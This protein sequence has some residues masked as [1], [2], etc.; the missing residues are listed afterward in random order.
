[1]RP[2]KPKRVEVNPAQ[3]G[4]AGFGDALAG[5]KLGPLP[6]GP[7]Q[8]Q[9][10][11]PRETKIRKLGRVILRKET[12]HRG[13]KAVIVIYDFPPTVTQSEL[14]DLAKHLRQSIGT[15]GTVRDRTVE[16]Q[17]EHAPKIRSILEKAGWCVT[18]V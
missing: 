10:V 9:P 18:G 16:I 2:E 6:E 11:G 8:P 3:A 14:E 13:G 1:M 17:G 4:L 15:G 5:L 12:A 7:P